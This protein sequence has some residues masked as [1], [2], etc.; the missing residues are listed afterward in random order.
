M[1]SVLG[2]HVMNSQI[3]PADYM[4]APPSISRAIVDPSV[5]GPFAILIAVTACF[6][7]AAIVLTLASYLAL[8]NS[9]RLSHGKQLRIIL[10]CGLTA[11]AGMIVLTQFRTAE[12]Q[13]LH[14]MGS[15]MLFFGFALGILLVGNLAATLLQCHADSP[16]LAQVLE[17]IAPVPRQSM[18]ITACAVIFGILYFGGRFAP[19]SWFFWQRAVLAVWEVFLLALFVGFLAGHAPL[20]WRASQMTKA[21]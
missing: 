11:V 10:A 8:A 2:A 3:R 4:E 18:G 16:A 19:D 9:L 14:N 5:G 20:V 13:A 6:I 21:A 15:Y 17:T 7:T 12:W 1:V